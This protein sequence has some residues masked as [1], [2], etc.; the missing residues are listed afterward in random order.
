MMGMGAVSN[1]IIDFINVNF[2][3]FCK[4][5]ELQCFIHFTVN[6]STNKLA[7]MHQ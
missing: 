5:Y 4:H 6:E 1:S 2:F 7:T 3:F